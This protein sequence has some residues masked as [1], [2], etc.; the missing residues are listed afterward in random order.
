MLFLERNFIFF[1]G[2]TTSSSA[3]AG[4]ADFAPKVRIGRRLV[5]L[6]IQSG[7]ADVSS[8]RQW[9]TGKQDLREELEA[10]LYSKKWKELVEESIDLVAEDF[11]LLSWMEI[12]KL[13][14]KYVE[15]PE[16]NY[17]DVDTSLAWFSQI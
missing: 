10:L 3:I 6:F 16:Y 1:K 15:Y 7:K 2:S 8:F 4:A 14:E 17:Y 9:I 11:R 12:M 13:N 5:D